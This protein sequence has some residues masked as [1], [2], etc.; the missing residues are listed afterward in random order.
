MTSLLCFA[1]IEFHCSDN[2]CS[3]CSDNHCSH[4]HCIDFQRSIT[5]KYR[6]LIYPFDHSEI[7]TKLSSHKKRSLELEQLAVSG[8]RGVHLWQ[9][10]SQAKY[11]II[12]V[13][14][15]NPQSQG[16]EHFILPCF[17]TGET[18]L[19]DV[20]GVKGV[21]RS[22]APTS[23]LWR[24]MRCRTQSRISMSCSCDTCLLG[25]LPGPNFQRQGMF[26]HQ[27]W[28]TFPFLR[29]LFVLPASSLNH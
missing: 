4:N 7:P 22:M 25:A 14:A 1:T 9:I 5:Q 27:S 18:F 21:K 13:Q 12:G 8:Q 16:L 28:G 15:R 29:G 23:N 26:C 2:Q 19:K 24:R 10:L 6:L 3:D 17:R 20:K 11:G